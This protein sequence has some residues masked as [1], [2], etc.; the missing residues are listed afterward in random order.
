[1][2]WNIHHQNPRKDAFSIIERLNGTPYATVRRVSEKTNHETFAS[3]RDKP[4][5]LV[6]EDEADTRELVIC[7][8]AADGLA[9]IS[10]ASVAEAI[11]ALQNNRIALTVLDWGLDRCGAEVLREMNQHC[12]QVPVIV[13]SGRPYDVRTDA[14]VGQADAFLAK[15]FS[16]TVLRNQV[17]RLLRRTEDH[18]PAMLPRNP[19]DI[20]PLSEIKELYI[21][22][23]VS[24]LNDNISLAA[25]KLGIHR[26]TVSVALKRS[27]PLEP[28]LAAQPA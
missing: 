24:L 7:T 10:A 6:V 14:I 1:V 27:W 22:H 2:W 19:E 9:C 23:V 28:V 8:L 11:A 15:P 13:M 3:G 25:E 4:L 18:A 21:R 17:L 26:Q 16:A 12:P 5:I 20:R